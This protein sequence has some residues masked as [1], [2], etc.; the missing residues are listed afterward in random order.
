MLKPAI[1][2]SP[3]IEPKVRLTPLLTRSSIAFALLLTIVTAAKLVLIL[4]IGLELSFDEAYYWHWSRHL[5]WCY[6]SKGP[7]IAAL[8]R[9]TTMLLGDTEFGIRAGA[10]ICSTTFLIVL[11][12][13]SRRFFEC[14]RTAFLTTLLAAATPLIL[15]TGVLTT[16]DSPL[17]LCWMTAMAAT[18]M[19]V[20]THRTFWWISA[21]LA[22]AA[23]IQFKFTMFFFAASFLLFFVGSKFDRTLFRTKGPYVVLA[24]AVAS[25]IPI[26]LWNASHDWITFLHTADKAS[27]GKETSLIT[28]GKIL[29]SLAQQLAVMSPVLGLGFLTAM[30]LLARNYFQQGNDAQTSS[31]GRLDLRKAWFLLSMALPIFAFYGLLSLHRMVEPNWTAAG[32]VSLFAAAA[33]YWQRTPSRWGRWTLAT[34]VVIG[35]AMQASIF[36]VD[37]AY[38]F[39]LAQSIFNKTT[40]VKPKVDVS[41][42]LHGWR[43]MASAV[44]NEANQIAKETGQEVAILA[45][46]YSYAAWVGFYAKMPE[47]VFVIPS[48]SGRPHNQFDTWALDGRRPSPGA[49]GLLV[50]ELE[51]SG[52]DGTY[53]FADLDML[54]RNFPI[55]RGK[56][57]I[58]RIRLDRGWDFQEAAWKDAMTR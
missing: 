26:L 30:V 27:T 42:R 18:W 38:R 28:V 19:A 32:Y 48:P 34:A 11:Y 3:T 5:D 44:E 39:D 17:L 47:S 20:Q 10:L 51:R 23:G 12:L 36:A 45:D 4:G 22:L 16:I 6:F 54:Y 56:V 46:H 31:R 33:F 8:I 24:A 53:L 40:G 52:R 13:W 25:M 41:N 1:G 21:G 50:Y 2:L 57:L 49:S 55:Y 58:R 35:F 9:A 7:G 14:E 37:A 43:E 29:P 15:G